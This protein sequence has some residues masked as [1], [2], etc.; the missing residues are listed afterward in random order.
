MGKL[1]G[2][3]VLKCEKIKAISLLK[4]HT[5][6]R[7]GDAQTRHKV[8]IRLCLLFALGLVSINAVADQVKLKNGDVITGDILKF[9][10]KKLIVKTNYAGEIKIT[11]SEVQS[12]TSEKPM[13]IVTYNGDKSYGI[14]TSDEATKSDMMVIDTQNS[15]PVKKISMAEIIYINSIPD[16]AVDEVKWSGN[17]NAGGAISEGNTQTRAVRFD[18]ETIARTL[19]NRYTLGGTFNRA[20]DRSVNSQFNSRAY[21]KYDYFFSSKW[22][23]Y[24]N[25]S[26]E[27]DRFRDI[28]LF[29]TTGIGS[30]YQIYESPELN[31]SV[32]GGIN[33]T[34]KNSYV[35][36]NE[37]YPGMRWALKYDQ[38]LFD[39]T[40]RL[41]HEHE[42]LTG[43]TENSQTTLR[44][45]TGLRFPLIFNFNAT[46]EF[47]YLWDSR[48]VN[49]LS[50]YDAKLLFTLGYGW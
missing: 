26:V 49:N 8:I 10:N 9:S 22:Y 1:C 12:L 3:A 35:L 40:T 13:H 5:S 45:K 27:N 29:T 6:I 48:P 33:Y 20:T 32:E 28:K 18:G 50:N 21:A 4:T 16:A 42:V 23:G 24:A 17:I 34:L 41:F 2:K 7:G 44:S 19:N 30:G 25:S 15:S 31:L 36:E 46:T 43:F 11:A 14:L 47:D 37:S 38:L 39:T